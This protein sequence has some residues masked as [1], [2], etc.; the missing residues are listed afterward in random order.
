[1]GLRLGFVLALA[2]ST[3][4][5]V[6]CSDLGKPLRLEPQPGVSATALDFGTVAVGGS[7]TR[8]VTVSNSGT[9]DFTGIAGVS[10]PGFSLDAGAGSFTVPP[11][12]QHEVV[13]RFTPGGIGDF[14]CELSLGGG[15]TPIALE[16]QASNQLPGSQCVVTPTTLEFGSLAS[17]QSKL[18]TFKIKNPGTAPTIL[19]VVSDRP[20]FAI[21]T[22]AGASN[23]APGDSVVVTVSYMPSASGADSCLIATGPGCPTVRG[24]GF[25]TTISFSRD[26]RPIM[27]ARFCDSC[28]EFRSTTQLVNVVS[29][30]G[31]APAVLIKPF[32]LNGSVLYGKIEN[33]GQYGQ[34]MPE[35]GP[36]LLPSERN[37]FRDWILEGA[38]NN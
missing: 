20:S 4:V 34:L 1:M 18:L 14:T 36:Q 25:G 28:H 6:G 8:S 29:Q 16:G 11:G 33:T 19:D 23:L 17:G 15:L 22:G 24:R 30:L 26:L 13:V 37:K 35:G 32:D 9:A 12:A 21:I 7:A 27:A 38:A 31:Y 2:S 10:C 3:I 5:A